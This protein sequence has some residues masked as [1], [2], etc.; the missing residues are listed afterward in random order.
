M[1]KIKHLGIFDS[2]LGGYTI[3]NE[4]TQE[5][6][7]LNMTLFADQINAP[8]GNKTKE[9][10]IQIT[11][12]ALNWFKT[13]GIND[14][15]FACNTVSSVALELIRADFKSMRLWG[16]IDLTLSQITDEMDNIGVLATKAT[17][18]THVYADKLEAMNKVCSE[19]YS[20]ELALAIEDLKAKEEIETII[21]QDMRSLK[22]A[23]YIILGCTHYPLVIDIFESISNA[24]FLDSTKP[25]IN[26][27]KGKYEKD[28]GIQKVYTSKDADKMKKQIKDLFKQDIE[29]LSI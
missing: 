11:I 1:N 27:I 9:E 4:L 12:D 5:F 29:V 13:Q 8:F 23:N 28:Q 3:F 24:V 7:D 16:I 18:D 20:I 17:I 25:I 2:G 14:V 26:F 19:A 21:K 10:I 6:P 15:L 22:N